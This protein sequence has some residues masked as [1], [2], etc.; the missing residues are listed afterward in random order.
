MVEAADRLWEALIMIRKEYINGGFPVNRRAPI[1]CVTKKSIL[2]AYSHYDLKRI[3]ES[4]NIIG[5]VGIWPGKMNTD[6]FILNPKKYSEWAPP[7]IHKDIDSAEE[8]IIYIKNKSF[9]RIEYKP[10]PHAEDQTV[11][12]SKDEKLYNY[13]INIGLKIKKVFE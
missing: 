7:E 2:V 3:L 9:D 6:C 12:V 5:C 1:L 8:V 4:E 10:G 13:L 11:I